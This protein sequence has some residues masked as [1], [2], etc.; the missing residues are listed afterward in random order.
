MNSFSEDPYQPTFSPIGSPDMSSSD[1]NLMKL[2]NA[3]FNSSV[4][5][6]LSAISPPP[7][8]ELSTSLCTAT[9]DVLREI[10]ASSN[11]INVDAPSEENKEPA[12]VFE[13]DGKGVGVIY[14]S[15]SNDSRSNDSRSMHNYCIILFSLCI[16]FNVFISLYFVLIIEH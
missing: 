6:S 8:L 2:A 15:R 11:D 1:L 7:V 10:A 12:E 9:S 16:Y 13:E 5:S 14:D 3:C 4:N